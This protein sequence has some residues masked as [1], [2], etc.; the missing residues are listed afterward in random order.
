MLDQETGGM[1]DT[2]HGNSNTAWSTEVI[3]KKWR[4]GS[5]LKELNDGVYL[6][7]GS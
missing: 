4:L 2:A 3:S 5:K 6:T 7:N 1:L